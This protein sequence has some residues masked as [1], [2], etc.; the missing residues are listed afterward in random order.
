MNNKSYL[1]TYLITL[2][3][4]IALV[5]LNGR[6]RLF[7]AIAVL[8]GIIF[9]VL[10]V[11]S[12]LGSFR[13]TKADKAAGRKPSVSL[14]VAS[15]GALGLGLLM[16]FAPGLFIHYLV[17]VIGIVLI[18]CGVLQLYNFVPSMRSFGLSWLYLGIPAVCMLAGVL[19]MI[20]GPAKVMNFM[21]LL[22]GS[23]LI[24]Y[25]LNG[26]VGYLAA[27]KLMKSAKAG[28]ELVDVK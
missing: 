22:T 25:S 9:L 27:A 16:V 26:F 14:A 17:Y 1:V 8:I 2:V 24:V 18:L 11:V 28:P 6:A 7:D 19:I 13:L 23:V 4:G 5:V 10:G 21:A 20:L 3:G 15:A 12:L